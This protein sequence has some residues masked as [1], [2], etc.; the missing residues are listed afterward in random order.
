MIF[1]LNFNERPIPPA[2]KR[3]F[4]ERVKV[5][6]P[7]CQPPI[8]SE[9]EKEPCPYCIRGRGFQWAYLKGVGTDQGDLQEMLAVIRN[10][11]RR[12][13]VETRSS[14]GGDFHGVYTY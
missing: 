14:A 10:G 4:A 1:G 3:K 7:E 2:I 9:L 8:D 5:P 12:I 13:H 6:C 11:S